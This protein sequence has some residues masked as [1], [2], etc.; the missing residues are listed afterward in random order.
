MH[1]LPRVVVPALGAAVIGLACTAGVTGC[2]SMEKALGQQQAIVTFK[3]GTPDSVILQVRTA[4]GTLPNVTPSPLPSKPAQ[5]VSL[6]EIVYDVTHA[7]P[8][9]EARLQQCLA[10][11]PSVQGLDFQDSTDIGA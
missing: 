5:A 8:A 7:S 9:D 4:C 6:G 11:Y 2:A 1:L 3:N 10:K